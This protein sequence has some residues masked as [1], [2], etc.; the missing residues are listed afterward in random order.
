M[1]K[2]TDGLLSCVLTLDNVRLLRYEFEPRQDEHGPRTAQDE[3]SILMAVAVEAIFQGPKATLENYMKG[4]KILNCAP[5]GPH[6]DPD[7]LFHWA[8]DIVGG[9]FKVIDVWTGQAEFQRFAETKLAAVAAKTGMPQPQTTFID[10]D[11]YL[12]SGS[13]SPL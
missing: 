2:L 1:R 9:G 13:P 4:L 7:C 5:G 12:T 6:P 10:V 3:G 11:S 8:T